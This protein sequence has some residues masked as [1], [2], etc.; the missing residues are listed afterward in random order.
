MV[1]LATTVAVI[2]TLDPDATAAEAGSGTAAGAGIGDSYFPLDGNRGIDVRR[3]RIGIDYSMTSGQLTGHTTLAVRATRALGRFNLDLLLPVTGVTVDGAP[4]VW[5][6]SHHEVAITPS[7]AIAEGSRFSVTVDYDGKPANHSYA[8]ESNWLASPEEVVAMNQPHM[9]PWW[10]PSNDHPRDAALM[11]ITVTTDSDRTV[12]ANGHQVSRSTDGTRATTR[13][14]SDEPMATYLAFFAAGDYWVRKGTHRGVDWLVAVSNDINGHNR[15]AAR[16]SVLRTP[17][18]TDWLSRRLGRYPF[19]DN[20]GLVT[21]LDVAFALENQT[22]PTYP[23]YWMS[24][25][26]LVHELAHQWFGDSVR[27]HAWRD[28][29]LNEG[30]ASYLEWVWS[31]SHGGASAHRRFTNGYRTASESFWRIPTGNPGAA[32]IFDNDAIYG[33][34]AMTLAALRARIGDKAFWSLARQWTRDRQG[35]TGS[36]RHF[37]ALAERISGEQ[38]DSFFRAWLYGTRKPA[39]TR[40]NG[41]GI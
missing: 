39:N 35:S 15:S 11:D 13:W 10:F 33:R 3:Y 22:R 8:G 36:T 23:S 18:V 34:G 32:H 12:I 38:L 7:T 6:Q 30:W 20:G 37:V 25:G 24:D 27:V 19:A 40:A 29:W 14:V 16:R 31:A 26:L 1:T 5:S 4:A 28:I 41:L 21:G 17:V 9:A 2:P